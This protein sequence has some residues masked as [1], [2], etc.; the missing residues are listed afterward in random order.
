MGGR[1]SVV[2]GFRH[3]QSPSKSIAN[4]YLKSANLNYV[5]RVADAAIHGTLR[6]ALCGNISFVKLQS[7]NGNSVSLEP[8]GYEFPNVSPDRRD[9]DSDWLMIRGTVQKGNRH[10]SFHEPSLLVDEAN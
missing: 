5:M 4:E 3:Q 2:S 6:V 1:R 9:L 7:Y 8:T 10:W